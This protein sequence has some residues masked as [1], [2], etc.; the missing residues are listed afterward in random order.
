[1]TEAALLVDLGNRALKA[2][3]FPSGPLPA[4]VLDWQPCVSRF[5]ATDIGLAQ[6][7]EWAGEN[8]AGLSVVLASVNPV[9]WRALSAC[10][11]PCSLRVVTSHNIPMVVKSS[12]SGIDRLLAGWAAFSFCKEAVV[13][14]DLGT[15]FTLDVVDEQGCFCGGA[16]GPGLGVQQQALAGACPHLAAPSAL[17]A[18]EPRTTAQATAFGTLAALAASLEGLASRFAPDAVRVL[19]GGDAATMQPWMTSEWRFEPDLVLRGLAAWWHKIGC[20]E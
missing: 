16:I 2:A 4:C 3:I 1:M 10:F 5:P 20:K 13:V 11:A 19:T 7:A 14:A 8:A 18:D 12:G 17:P 9:A 6:F 15:A